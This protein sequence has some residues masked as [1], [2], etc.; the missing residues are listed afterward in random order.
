MFA[1][2][3]WTVHG[4]CPRGHIVLIVQYGSAT[5]PSAENSKVLLPRQNH[6]IWF[7]RCIR[8]QLCIHDRQISVDRQIVMGRDLPSYSAP[9]N[10]GFRGHCEGAR[11]PIR[12]SGA[13]G[14]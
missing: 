13:A 12:D 4:R 5:V 3:R 11:V 1:R 8:L 9:P 7:R 10:L 6:D 14:N 2:G